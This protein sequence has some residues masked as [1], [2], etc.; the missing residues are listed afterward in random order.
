ML[1]LFVAAALAACDTCGN[2]LYARFGLAPGYTN[3]N[4]GSYGCMPNDV[5]EHFFGLEKQVELNPDQ[6][7]RTDY[8]PLQNTNKARVAKYV[9]SNDEDIVFVENASGGVNAFLRSFGR[10]LNAGDKVLHLSTVYGMVR[11]VINLVV[12]EEAVTTVEVAL[13]VTDL[14]S[15]EATLAAIKK[16]VDVRGGP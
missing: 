2:G 16:E 4:H 10:T 9:G 14:R 13:S 15:A 3:F 11:Q 8:R 5:R 6:W 7:F 12:E 1:H